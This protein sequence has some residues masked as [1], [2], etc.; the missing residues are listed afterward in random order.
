MVNLFHNIPLYAEIKYWSRVV[1]MNKIRLV[2]EKFAV[3]SLLK[4]EVNGKKIEGVCTWERKWELMREKVSWM[5]KLSSSLLGTH[6]WIYQ[7]C[8]WRWEEMKRRSM[9]SEWSERKEKLF[10]THKKWKN[11]EW[12]RKRERRE[13]NERESCY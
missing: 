1:D 3:R 7:L 9:R 8:L 13:L 2:M 11:R 5:F 6:F 10:F 12:E 4:W